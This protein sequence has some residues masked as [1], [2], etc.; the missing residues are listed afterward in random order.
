MGGNQN[1]E[2]KTTLKGIIR[3]MQHRDQIQAIIIG[4]T[5]LSIALKT[6]ES[7]IKAF[8]ALDILSEKSVM[9]AYS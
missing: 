2:D 7:P 4:C 1:K 5:E 6:N 3:K 9:R 8:D